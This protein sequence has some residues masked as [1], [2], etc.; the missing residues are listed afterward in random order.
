MILEFSVTMEA[1]VEVKQLRIIFLFLANA[2]NNY[3][4]LLPFLKNTFLVT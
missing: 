3:R 1:A 2:F 4:F